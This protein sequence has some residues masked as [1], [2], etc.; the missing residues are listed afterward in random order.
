MT[1]PKALI[2]DD[3]SLIRQL[4]KKYLSGQFECDWARSGQ[5]ALELT[6]K[7]L[8]E[9]GGYALIM[10][11]QWMTGMNGVEAVRAIRELERASRSSPGA[12]I[13][14]ATSDDKLTAETLA[15]QDCA[16]SGV[17]IKPVLQE[18]IKGIIAEIAARR[19]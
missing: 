7:R 1:L 9:G 15:D 2:A 19:S 3:S 10:M 18:H 11:D 13:Y 5:E 14:L 4:F 6:A 16:V 8:S 12:T 17:L